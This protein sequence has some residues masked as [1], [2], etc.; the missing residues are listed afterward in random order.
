MSKHVLDKSCQSLSENKKKEEKHFQ[1]YNDEKKSLNS[2]HDGK[3][4]DI[5][6]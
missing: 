6:R 5:R 1:K 2:D 4:R 3:D